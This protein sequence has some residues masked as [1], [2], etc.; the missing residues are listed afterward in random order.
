M[1]EFF[2]LSS[3]IKHTPTKGNEMKKLLLTAL[4]VTLLLSPLLM[5]KDKIYYKV[6]EI[7]SK[8]KGAFS[9]VIYKIGNFCFS[10]ISGAIANSDSAKNVITKIEVY[11]NDK[12][13]EY[14]DILE[15]FQGRIKAEIIEDFY[16]DS[17]NYHKGQ[18]IYFHFELKQDAYVYLLNVSNN[19][20]CLVYPNL[21]ELN[22]YELSRGEHHLPSNNSY[23]I[24]VDGS[25][26]VEKFYLITALRPLYFDKFKQTGIFKCASRGVALQE[27]ANVQNSQFN[28]VSLIKLN[29]D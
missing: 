11:F 21:N 9:K 1:G 5:A 7:E 17:Q 20:A 4:I 15:E 16:T 10:I 28:D 12:N 27:V 6:Q 13:S 3:I 2:I 24:S 22:S 19:D 14:G 8:K 29:I 23:S 26:K 25:S 18:N